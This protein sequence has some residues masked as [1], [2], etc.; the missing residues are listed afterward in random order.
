MVL[1]FS[2]KEINCLTFAYFHNLTS[3]EKVLDIVDPPLY[4]DHT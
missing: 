4:A 2:L 1:D 3:P